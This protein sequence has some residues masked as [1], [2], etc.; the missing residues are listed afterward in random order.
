MDRLSAPGFGALEGARRRTEDG[1]AFYDSQLTH[2][3]GFG[4]PLQSQPLDPRNSCYTEE[5]VPLE[6]EW[7][8]G[9]RG[10]GGSLQVLSHQLQALVEWHWAVCRPLGLARPKKSDLRR[11]R[12][13]RRARRRCRKKDTCQPCGQTR[14]GTC[15]DMLPPSLS[16]CLGARHRIR[17]CRIK[18]HA[19]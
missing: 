4:I 3:H 13:L 17:V 11:W 19:H 5:L 10:F 1:V 15:L 6:E 9:W 8:W 16:F 7:G 18:I 14:T 12:S 2:P